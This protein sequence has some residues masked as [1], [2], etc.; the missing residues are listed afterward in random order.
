M[1]FPFTEDIFPSTDFNKVN[2]DW[3]CDTLQKDRA[4][5]D[6]NTAD[7]AELKNT[8]IDYDD[9][10]N[11]PQINSVTLSGNKSLSDIGAASADELDNLKSAINKYNAGNM[12]KTFRNA[13]SGTVAGITYTSDA[14][15]IG[16]SANGTATEN[17]QISYLSQNASLPSWIVPGQYYE[18]GIDSTDPGLRLRVFPKV[19]GVLQQALFDG[20]G[21]GIIKI[22]EG[23]TNL[24]VT[25]L[26]ENGVTVT[27]AHAY[28]FFTNA[29]SNRVLSDEV[30]KASESAEA[31]RDDLARYVPADYTVE[32]GYYLGSSGNKAPLSGFDY[33]TV[34]L[35][36]LDGVEVYGYQAAVMAGI[37]FR[38]ASNNNLA[39]RNG[40]VFH[41][42]S[43]GGYITWKLLKPAGA[44]KAVCS[45]STSNGRIYYV[46]GISCTIDP[47]AKIEMPLA[48]ITMI[49]I[50]GQSLSVGAAAT[51]VISASP[52]YNAGLM[53]NGGVVAKQ[54]AVSFFTDFQPLAESN[55]E[56]PASGTA[57][58]LAEQIQTEDGVSVISEYWN[59]HH[60]LLVSCGEGSKTIA[61]L[62]SDYYDGLKAAVQGAKNICDSNG[63]T[64]N[65]PCWIWIQGETDQKEDTANSK[66]A[67]SLSDYKTALTNLQSGFNT[68]VKS[69]TGQTNDI[70]C[71]CYQSASQNIVAETKTPSY[72][73]TA[74]MG[75]PTAQMQL[76]RDNDSFVAS[77][78][79]YILDH[80]TE[81]PIHLS[82]VGSKMLG[83]YCGIAAK[84]VAFG[85]TAPT[86]LVPKSYAID[87]TKLTIKYDVPV[88][89]IRIDT[90][91]VKEVAHYGFSLLDSSNNDLISSV[92]A[93]DDTVEIT[94]SASPTNAMLF[95]G[96]NGSNGKDG[97]LQGS[98]GNIC[99]SAKYI[100]DG[101][102][103]G[104]RYALGNYA[105]SFVK[106]LS[107]SSGAI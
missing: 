69:V 27:N 91:W 93:F 81:Q 14:D 94:C 55:Q 67:T 5:I 86:G 66:S 99:D 98:R 38:D 20:S 63:L 16:F 107:S 60:V 1:A 32:S 45:F 40:D 30:E 96:F 103:A 71:I 83:L 43:S 12:I 31:I 18:V 22:P 100:F 51:P 42:P 35:T 46:K 85:E 29:L 11:K 79:V 88:P 4:D 39:D 7:I 26:I 54:K 53:F 76:V 73:N 28:P 47:T 64:L 13:P 57:D 44:T 87:G 75:V 56:T 84:A 74:V 48:D 89:P 95:Y 104:K 17:A 82:N 106:L 6:Q 8:V 24:M 101:E 9:L 58:K 92:S 80:S 77:A 65:V 50:F 37:I 70:V 72:T 49:P 25:T 21:H 97:R 102:I 2:L 36:N 90:E 105:Y 34:D 52:K 23:T 3:I 78:P 62:V 33:V 15:K 41:I 59:N 19:G 68:Y 61:D 10:I